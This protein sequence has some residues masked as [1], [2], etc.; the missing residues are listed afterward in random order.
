MFSFLKKSPKKPA[1]KE[2]VWVSKAY[3]YQGLY[4]DIK[5]TINLGGKTLIFTHFA[6]TY[7]EIAFVLEQMSVN[8][9]RFQKGDDTAILSFNQVA[10][11]QADTLQSHT[12]KQLQS[13]IV[14]K[15]DRFCIIEHFPMREH[16]D[17]LLDTL[18]EIN[19]EVK[20]TFYIS[21]D[22]AVLKPFIGENLAEMLE[23]LGMKPEECISHPLVAKSIV[24]VQEKLE[25]QAKNNKMTYSVE[26]WLK[27]NL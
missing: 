11:F 26:E 25:K 27:T 23:K 20:P 2:N 1:Y 3:K 13:L 17:T 12:I 5:E 14:P 15:S 8:F 10:V 24:N 21:L 22:D 18:A 4:E 7:E 19:V 6:K 16:D 9:Y